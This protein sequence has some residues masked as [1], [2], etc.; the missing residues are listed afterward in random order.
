MPELFAVFRVLL[1]EFCP[2]QAAAP[3]SDERLES[4]AAGALLLLRV[5]PLC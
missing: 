5:G 2:E 1:R 4:S 3:P